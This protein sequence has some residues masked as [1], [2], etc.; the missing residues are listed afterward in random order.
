[1]K[2]EQLTKTETQLK[3]LRSAFHTKER[4]CENLIKEKDFLH[5]RVQRL[6][7]Q[8]DS[9]E[10]V[11]IREEIVRDPNAEH[12]IRHLIAENDRLKEDLLSRLLL[13]VDIEKSNCCLYTDMESLK[14]CRFECERLKDLSRRAE[15]EWGEERQQLIDEISEL[16]NTG[17]RGRSRSGDHSRSENKL[18]EYNR[19]YE[20]NVKSKTFQ[21]TSKTAGTYSR[22]DV[23]FLAQGSSNKKSSSRILAN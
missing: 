18:T 5:Y 15:I 14:H 2:G 19:Y 9:R 4:E 21:S 17:V 8:V 23:P 11:I 1:M 22:P 10:K 16:R 20:S 6:E 3:E 12:R 13:R 7:S